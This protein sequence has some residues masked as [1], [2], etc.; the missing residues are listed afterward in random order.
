MADA[1]CAEH[2]T[3]LFFSV[4][5][6]STEKALAICRGCLVRGECLDDALADPTLDGSGPARRKLIVASFE[7]GPRELP[8]PMADV[9]LD[10][11]V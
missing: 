8:D 10:S 1:A 4:G 5:R 7:G 9:T 2:K 11:G 3:A 6:T